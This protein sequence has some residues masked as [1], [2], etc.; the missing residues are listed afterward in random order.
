MKN[1]KQRSFVIKLEA[2]P[3]RRGPQSHRSG[4]G[5]HDNRP[6]RLRTRAAQ[7]RAALGEY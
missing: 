3:P 5:V 7:R 6:H 2:K 1:K 4:A